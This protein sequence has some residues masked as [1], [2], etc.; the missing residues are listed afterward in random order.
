MLEVSIQ[1]IYGVSWQLW[2]F[3]CDWAV[4][5]KDTGLHH[6]HNREVELDMGG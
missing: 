1:V 6:N 5:S 2:L 4:T 3:P